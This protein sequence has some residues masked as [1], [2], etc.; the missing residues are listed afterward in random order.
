M[1]DDDIKRLRE[2]AERATDVGG[3]YSVD[4][5]NYCCAAS[6]DVLLRLLDEREALREAARMALDFCEFCWR[7]VALNEYAEER[8]AGVEHRLREA[9]GGER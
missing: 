4:L 1:T 7:D 6:P 3:P 5:W 9:L 2:L 8:R